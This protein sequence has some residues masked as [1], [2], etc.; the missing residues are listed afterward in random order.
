MKTKSTTKIVMLLCA[1]L[2]STSFF[3]S[4]ADQGAK[5][6]LAKMEIEK[7]ELQKQ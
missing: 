2:V 7:Q 4:C 5:E 1:L 3:F 6:Q